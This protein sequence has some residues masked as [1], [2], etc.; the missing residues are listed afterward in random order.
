VYE[1]GLADEEMLDMY[2]GVPDAYEKVEMLVQCDVDGQGTKESSA[3]VYIDQ[4]RVMP[5]KP[6]K[7]YVCRM[8]R[9]IEEAVAVWQLPEWYVEEV[10]R[11]FIPAVVGI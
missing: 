4:L 3:L 11:G 8:N 9:G 5:S 10:M 7:E 2:E 1:L 6:R